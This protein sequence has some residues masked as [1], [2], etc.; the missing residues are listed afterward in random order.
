MVSLAFFDYNR[1]RR[2]KKKSAILVFI[3]IHYYLVEMEKVENFG[4]F[5]GIPI[6]K[7][8]LKVEEISREN[9]LGDA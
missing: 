4:N 9:A 3:I 6:Q 2:L 5:F 7:S 1:W 8:I